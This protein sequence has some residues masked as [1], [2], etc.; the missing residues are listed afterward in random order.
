MTKH[1]EIYA[2][3]YLICNLALFDVRIILLADKPNTCKIGFIV[4][5]EKLALF[6]LWVIDIEKVMQPFQILGL[7][8][9]NNHELP[10]ALTFRKLSRRL[11]DVED[12]DLIFINKLPQV[13][14]KPGDGLRRKSFG[15]LGEDNGDVKAAIECAGDDANKRAG[16]S[17]LDFS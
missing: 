11:H 10:P 7:F 14:A 8:F 16:L 17:G 12:E 5:D 1:S 6:Q 3:L 9:R 15:P 4:Y 2:C 13:A